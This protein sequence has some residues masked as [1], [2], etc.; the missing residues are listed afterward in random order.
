M[1]K[2]NFL[3]QWPIFKTWHGFIV[4]PLR[5][6]YNM[7]ALEALYRQFPPVF[8]IDIDWLLMAPQNYLKYVIYLSAFSDSF[9]P[10][11]CE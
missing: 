11:R 9:N 4:S 2:I 1:L 6:G 3:S 8:N 5:V 10:P 7:V